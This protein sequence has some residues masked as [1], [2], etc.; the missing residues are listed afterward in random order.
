[1]GEQD[2]GAWI[3]IAVIAAILL[4]RWQGCELTPGVDPSPITDAGLRVLITFDETS[5]GN[6]PVGQKRI[7]DS[8]D[9]RAWL[10]AKCVKT[11]DG[12]PEWRLWPDDTAAAD[13]PTMGKL[14]DIA[15]GKD[16]WLVIADGTRGTSEAL[17]PTLEDLTAKLETYGGGK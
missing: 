2:K 9:L 5:R 8:T 16:Q 6:L 3:W 7:L 10:D 11:S 13:S 1:M 15:R 4:M 14:L 12:R 17:P